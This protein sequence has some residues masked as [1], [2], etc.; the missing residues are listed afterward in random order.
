MNLKEKNSSELK[1]LAT[2]LRQKIIEVVSVNGGHLSSNLGVVELTIA[3]HKVFN[4]PDDKLIFDTSHQIYTHKLLTGRFD[5]FEGIRKQDGLYGFSAPHESEHD[6]FYAG[7]AAT[8]LS[9]ALGCANGD[10]YTVPII[11]DA[12]F[13]CGLT[14]EA[15]DNIPQDL[16]RFII[17][18]N[19][20]GMSIAKNVGAISEV[21]SR[22]LNAPNANRFYHETANFLR[23]IPS[24]GETLA[25]AGKKIKESAKTL[26]N[27]EAP[28]FEH[29]NLAYVGPVDGHNI[30][31][32]IETLES[33][34]SLDKPTLIH[35]KTV[36]GFGMPS[37]EKAPVAYH[38]AKP[39]DPETGEF[40]PSKACATFPKVFGK[41][42]QEMAEHDDQI[43][44]ISPA[45]PHGT[46]VAAF[47]E[48]FPERFYDVGIAEGHAVTFAAGLA[49]QK[50]K[51]IVSIYATF[52][53][54]AFDNVFHDVCI[55]N[56]PVIFAIDRAGIS[57]GDG[58]THHGIY[59]ISFLS[60]MPNLTIA[61]PRNGQVL[62]EL[63][64][65]AFDYG[66]PVAI[67]Y[68]NLTTAPAQ[69]PIKNRAKGRGEILAQGQNIA[70]IAL[71]HM[72]D[73]ALEARQKLQAE[74]LNITVVDPIFIKPLDTDLLHNLAM[75]HSTLITLEEH[76]VTGGLGSLINSYVTQNGCKDTTVI[77]L[78]I[79]DEPIHPGSHST[80]LQKLGLDAA[81]IAN[82]ILETQA[83]MI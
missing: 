56:L 60:A 19:D 13:T 77:N 22:L 75:T 18:L 65:S 72:C 45:T 9:L 4:S 57:G 71:G 58:I 15:L 38:G 74:G 79:S 61:Q 26:I 1:K 39:F 35:V 30:D 47:G 16:K 50:K 73:I 23:K 2:E 40:A 44:V 37:A 66:G 82:Q 76:L 10:N 53:Q 67:R 32:L 78:G 21:L 36:K 46:C 6:H 62:C 27:S 80:I 48:S 33:V 42:V 14:Y 20:N 52:L 55:Q 34:K 59:D 43:C 69:A 28:F 17:I 7:H 24:I 5:Q 51:P 68:P 64:Q 8:A 49:Y 63:M 25:R 12:A 81:S 70:I 3:L 54:R 41:H 11:G 83:Q 31:E 29:F